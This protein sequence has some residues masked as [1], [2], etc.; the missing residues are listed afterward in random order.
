M[1]TLASL[2]FRIRLSFVLAY[3]L[4]IFF[5]RRYVVIVI[6]FL[7]ILVVVFTGIVTYWQ[8][9]NTAWSPTPRTIETKLTNNVSLENYRT[10]EIP[11]EETSLQA[12]YDRLQTYVSQQPAHRD[13]LINLSI[14]TQNLGDYQSSEYWLE[15]A[16]NADPNFSLFKTSN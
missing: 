8:L 13:I 1:A 4:G 14:L 2:F 16:K 12:E 15:S 6:W 7:A 5:L 9:R 11:Q 3:T 10:Y